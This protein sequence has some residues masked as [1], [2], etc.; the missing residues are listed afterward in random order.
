[1]TLS[2][3]QESE[4]NYLRRQVDAAHDRLLRNDADQWAQ[5]NL[6]YA[7]EELRQF[8]SKLRKEGHNI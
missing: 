4:L 5:Q 3:A 2:P 8:V 6:W 1:M 7:R